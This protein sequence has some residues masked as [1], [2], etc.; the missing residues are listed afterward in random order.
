ME[1]AWFCLVLWDTDAQKR[2]IFSTMC[3]Y[4]FRMHYLFFPN[5]IYSYLSTTLPDTE[6]KYKGNVKSQVTGHVVL[7]CAEDLGSWI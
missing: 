5:N 4:L 1:Y 6:N 7:C 3:L 2:T